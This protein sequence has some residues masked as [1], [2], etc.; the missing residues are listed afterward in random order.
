M[1]I[2]KVL[3]NSLVLAIDGSG[4]ECILMGK[5][6][7]YKKSIGNE[8]QPIEVEKTFILKDKA[9][10][11][12]FVQLASELDDIYFNI[13]KE[14]IKYASENY[15]I[16]VMDYLYLSLS[17]HI[18][19]VIDRV[20]D[21]NIGEN[22]NYI[23]VVKFHK[24]EYEVGQYA[25]QLI[26]KQLGIQLPDSEASAIGL[27]FVN[28]RLN[29]KSY[30]K[31]IELTKL[32]NNIEAIVL[33]KTNIILDKK[34][35]S[36]L[37][38]VTHLNYFAERIIENQLFEDKESDILYDQLSQNMIRENDIIDSICQFVK[39][40]YTVDLTKQEKIYLMIHIH[41][42]MGENR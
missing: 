19:F 26:N 7:G 39:Q 15:G 28:A 30:N 23:E 38:F 12:S 41:R 11:K 16:E 32:V 42:I 40:K 13:V 18:A 9:T 37:R 24:Y 3:N 6:I 14:I 31:E 4:N 5:G 33:R 21:G 22:F 10:L 29:S 8:I 20:K 25:V 34:S 27:H 2:L 36:Y 35:F 17:D 1:Q